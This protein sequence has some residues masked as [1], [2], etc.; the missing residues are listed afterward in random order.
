M[1]ILGAFL[2]LALSQSALAS[3]ADLEL[4]RA[5]EPVLSQGVIALGRSEF[6]GALSAADLILRSH[7]KCLKA[8]ELRALAFKGLKRETDA[9][10]TYQQA[11]LAIV[12]ET[13][14]HDPTAPY[15]FEIGLI[16]LHQKKRQEARESF[17][18]ALNHGFN[19]VAAHFFLGTLD[20]EE[21]GEL[22][23]AEGHFRAVLASNVEDLK[24]SAAYYLG[25]AQGQKSDSLRSSRNFL[26]ARY[27]SSRQ[28]QDASTLPETRALAGRI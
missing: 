22:E 13:G 24:P 15:V 9:L 21:K 4:D 10:A 26:L 6:Q 28:L 25:Q 20:L 1:K 7:P 8:L 5:S 18:F 14:N 17:Q 11:A 23:S 16:R 19:P 2:A 12:D 3:P 27:L